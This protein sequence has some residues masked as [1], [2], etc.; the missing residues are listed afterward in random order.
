MD[1]EYD[2][3]MNIKAQLNNG[4]LDIS[5]IY[6]EEEIIVACKAIEEY[7]K[8]HYLKGAKL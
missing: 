5:D 8:N 2:A 3:L 4:Y 6:D 7:E 1:S